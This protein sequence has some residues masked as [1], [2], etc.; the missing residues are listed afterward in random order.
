MGRRKAYIGNNIITTPPY[1]AEA[2]E[3]KICDNI[4]ANGTLLRAKNRFSLLRKR[5]RQKAAPI[6]IL[7][8]FSTFML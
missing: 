7:L 8:S 5:S 6:Q 3:I 2:I 1:Y 4:Q